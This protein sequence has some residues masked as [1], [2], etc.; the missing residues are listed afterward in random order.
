MSVRIIAVIFLALQVLCASCVP[1][2]T[3][4]AGEI[5]AL[6][7][8]GIFVLCEGLW[9]QD[10]AVLSYINADNSVVRDVVGTYNPNTKLGDIAT[11]M[12]SMSDTLVIAVNTSRSLCLVRKTDGKWLGRIATPGVKQPFHLALASNGK[13]Y[14]TNIN[15][16]SIT[17]Y[18]A[19][20]M[21]VTVPTVKVGP[22]PEGIT[23][24]GKKIYVA[25]SGYGDL[26]KDEEGAGT[27]QVLSQQDLS[28][29]SVI[30]DL[31][32][33]GVVRSDEARK[34]VWATFRH[35]ASEPDSLGG[36]VL[37]DGRTDVVMNL[38]RIKSPLDITI[39]TLSGNAYVMHAAGVDVLDPQTLATTRIISHQSG[40]GSD[41]W[42]SIGF[43]HDRRLILI[44]N[45]RS[46]VTDG[47]VIVADLL[48]T[49]I[50]RYPVGPNPISFTR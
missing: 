22:A 14:C 50:S 23:V 28:T 38:W 13:L 17:E 26:R 33:V 43:D 47:E 36:V 39:D 3:A 24:L 1:T 42:Y 35:F 40:A 31:P 20:T 5:K 8:G 27:I 48:G 15:D 10:N 30:G 7:E 11:D 9:R 44:G 49:I 4:P 2:P 46:Y 12:V 32:N 45:A 16:D 21:E 29:L 18:D 19:A 34:F 41:I 25:N 37:I 6:R